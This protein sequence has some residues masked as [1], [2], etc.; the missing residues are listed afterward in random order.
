MRKLDRKMLRDLW[1]IKEQAVAI[2]AVIACGVA[3]FVMA[4]STL[5][6]LQ[7]TQ[8]TYYDRYRFAEMFARLK[9]APLSLVQRIEDIP[10]VKRVDPRIVMDVTLDVAG[11]TEPAV[12]RLI[13]IPDSGEPELNGVYL[14]RGRKLEPGHNDE[15][16]VSEGFA[17]AHGFEPG[18]RVAAIIN[19]RKKMLKIVGVVLS[20]EYIYQIR[21]GGLIPDDKRFGVFWMG[22]RPLEAAFDMD[23]ALND[24]SLLLMPGANVQEVLR[25]LDN[26]TEPYGGT[27]AF[28]RKDQ[29]SHQLLTNEMQQLR[30]MSLIGPSIFLSVAAF[31]LN[32]VI[33]RII[34]AQREQIAA[35]KAFGYSNRDIGIH[36]VKLVLLI[37]LVGGI[38][39]VLFGGWI[40]SR[41]TRIYGRFYRFP[42]LQY[43]LNL[44]TVIL[45]LF[46]SSAA[47]VAGSI[48]AVRRAV[49][50]PP[51]EAM[52]PEP[53][54]RY[55]P[56]LVEQL[57]M[58]RMLTPA[59]RMILR[60]LERQPIKSTLSSLGISMAVAVLIFGSFSIDAL[61]YIIDVQ[62]NFAQRYDVDVSF[63]EPHPARAIHALEH[64]PGVMRTEAYRAVPVRLRFG[65]R[66]RRQAITG[67]VQN[68]E[69]QRTIDENIHPI[70]LPQEGIALGIKLA[71]L[72]GARLGDIITVE[73]MEGNR[74]V[75]RIP[76]TALVSEFIGAGAYMNIEALNRLLQ[77]GA[78]VSGAYLMT[79]AR[80]AD[81]LYD[82]LK[83]TPDVAAVSV[84]K[85]SIRNFQDTIAE[86]MLRM[87]LF[88][89]G[90]ATVI[91]CGVVYNSARIALAERSRELASLRVMG[92]T[93]GEISTILLGELA[94]LTL[95]AL[96]LGV[97]LGTGFA[98][99][100]TSRLDTELFRIPLII[101]P[102][103][104]A[105]AVSVV[106]VAAIL[107]GL[108]V[109]RKLDHLDLVSVLKS[110]E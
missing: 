76:V 8:Q 7:A 26:L 95:A 5:F 38:I 43:H 39:G 19:R 108:I 24:I 110:R 82:Q 67:Y 29:V 89:V 79:D 35:L 36:Y 2:A 34:V 54:A 99:V 90:F 102:T 55:K 30:A 37:T 94:V 84:R 73:V 21:A 4:L 6:S 88:N 63:Y 104:Y 80:L 45:A 44:D 50:L 46:I 97:G 33:A 106:L 83:H 93:R 75:R 61:D 60:H 41:L 11:M 42:I 85:V 51:A 77:E 72:L 91:A 23:G 9:R 32:V 65:H 52:R 109:R 78:T 47:A 103:T 20:P 87:R 69:L 22:R 58:G 98:Y 18:D 56:T 105:F 57:G 14:R 49:K 96:P 3:T 13:S 74:Q 100:L 59:M 86:N 28:A 53:P 27:G 10:G 66:S 62:F 71:E 16:L 64:L 15:V 101:R 25:R 48:G 107:S 12:G 1:N 40:G 17:E 81:T 31:L 68:P 92:F 70:Q